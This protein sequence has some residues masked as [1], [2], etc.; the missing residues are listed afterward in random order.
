MGRSNGWPM[1]WISW[2]AGVH[3]RAVTNRRRELE[4]ARLRRARRVGGAGFAAAL[5]LPVVLWHRV[6]G[7]IA[8]QFDFSLRYF[9]TGW[10]PWV[11]MLLGLACFAVVAVH[12]WRD[13]ERRFYGPGTGAWFGWGVTLYLLGFGLATQVAQITQGISTT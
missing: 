4:I 9:V 1:L 3:N 10:S 13:R 2:W 12:D 8:S 5:L 11:L 7:A 6:I